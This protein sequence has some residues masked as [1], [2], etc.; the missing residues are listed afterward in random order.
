VKGDLV[1]ARVGLRLSQAQVAEAMGIAKSLYQRIESLD[2][3][4]TVDLPKL[5][6]VPALAVEVYEARLRRL[7]SRK[8]RPV[9]AEACLTPMLRDLSDVSAV[10]AD[11]VV[12]AD[13]E[14]GLVQAL[15]RIIDTAQGAIESIR[16]R[17]EGR[18]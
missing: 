9:K 3:E 11:G 18:R 17:R 8:R 14:P 16:A 1:L 10:L 7:G 13:E 4:A 6:A 2:D 5:E 15:S 12:T